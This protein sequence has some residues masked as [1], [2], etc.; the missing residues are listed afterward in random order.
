[1][2]AGRR[3]FGVV[4]VVVLGA[5]SLVLVGCGSSTSA[6]LTPPAAAGGGGSTPVN[7]TPVVGNTTLT[8]SEKEFS[9]TP[10]T[11]KA[12]TGK[13]DVFVNNDGT[14]IHNFAVDVGGKPVISADV[15]PGQK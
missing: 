6:G 7:G 9:I 1:M 12:H 13:I 4:A 2:V 14:I 8:M 5:V 11:A 3:W 10:A 15:K